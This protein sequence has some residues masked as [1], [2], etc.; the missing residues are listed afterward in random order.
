[1]NKILIT[2][3]PTRAY[4]DSVRY[5]SNV[6]TGSL[7]AHILKQSV[8]MDFAVD[9]VYGSGAL[10]PTELESLKAKQAINLY[11]INDFYELMPT[12]KDLLNNNRYISIIHSMAVLDYIPDKIF[13]GKISSDKDNLQINLVR[14]SKIIDIFRKYAPDSFIIGFKLDVDA[15]DDTLI[16]KARAL[17][18]RANIDLVCANNLPKQEHLAIFVNKDG[19]V[20]D[21]VAGKENIA[22]KLID[23]VYNIIKGHII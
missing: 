6:S 10:L 19:S 22:I 16:R 2:A 23:I 14:A 20:V 7:G 8:D 13:D 12:I 3:G 21:R 15:D 11:Q 9:Y 4:I 5:I 18:N 17:I 1:V